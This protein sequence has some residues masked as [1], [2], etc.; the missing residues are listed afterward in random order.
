MKYLLLLFFISITFGQSQKFILL[1][2]ETLEF[3]GEVNYTLYFNNKPIFSNLTSK[4]SITRLPKDV[5]FDSIAFSKFN[6]KIAGFK[7]ENLTEVVLLN[8]TVYELDEV[9]I[10]NSKPKEVVIGEESR[11]I[12]NKS[13]ALSKNLDYGILFRE[14]DLKNMMIKRMIFFVEKVTY[15]TSYKIK[16]YTANEIGDF[17][18]LLQLQVKELLF[19]SPILTI[20]KGTKN[21]VEVNLEEY[22]INLYNKNVFICLELQDYFD[23]NNTIIQPQLSDQTQLKYQI[24]NLTNYYTKTYDLNTKKL[25]NDLININGMINRDFAFMFFKKPHKSQLVA[26]AILLYAVK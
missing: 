16:F 14:N 10:S 19:E 12:K 25:S 11:F 6:Y 18:T 23:E 2:N 21:K 26:P 9:I 20:E 17:M 15:K 8:R 3:I 24:S 7:K 1:D 4:D 13:A 22:E 5:S